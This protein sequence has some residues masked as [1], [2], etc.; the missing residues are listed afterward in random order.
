MAARHRMTET[1]GSGCGK[2]EK[3]DTKDDTWM[4]EGK[5]T[6][7]KSISVT[8]D[9]LD[10]AWRDAKH[11][12]KLPFIDL[13]FTRAAKTRRPRHWVLVPGSVFQ[14]LKHF[15]KL[16]PPSQREVLKP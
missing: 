12:G 16:L 8:D 10:K 13:D 15:L 9:M 5:S 11:M 7:G 3:G 14:V 2:K 4:G 1:R 6:R